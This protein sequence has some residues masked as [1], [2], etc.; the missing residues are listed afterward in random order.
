[1][2]EKDCQALVWEYNEKYNKSGNTEKLNLIKELK[3]LNILLSIGA[4]NEE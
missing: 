3:E 1:M 4:N 2:Q